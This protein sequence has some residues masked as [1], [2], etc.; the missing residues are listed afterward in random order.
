ME[1]F[2]NGFFVGIAQTITGHPFDT[3]KV[4]KQT[5]NNILLKKIP[6]NRLYKGISYPLIGSC[7]LNSVQFGT[8]HYLAN[9]YHFNPFISGFISGGFSSI[10]L[11]PIEM[12][13]IKYQLLNKNNIYLWRGFHLTFLRETFSTSMYFSSYYYLNTD[14]NSF[15]S[16]GLSGI[17]SWFITYHIDVLKT[18]IQSNHNL[19]LIDAWKQGNMWKGL[20]FCLLRS[21]IVNGTG[22]YIY[23]FLKK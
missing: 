8:Y 7:A 20:S 23:D 4:I 22:F 15:I 14:Y 21:F 17:L 12:Y 11:N 2:T 19:K 10:I 3:I 13:K 6:L 16:G 9:T 1:D 5:N 18:R